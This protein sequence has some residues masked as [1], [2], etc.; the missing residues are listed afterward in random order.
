VC[1]ESFRNCFD[2]WRRKTTR[3]QMTSIRKAA[4]A[5]DLYSAEKVFTEIGFTDSSSRLS[6]VVP[7]ERRR[8]LFARLS[9]YA[10]AWWLSRSLVNP[11]RRPVPC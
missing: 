4:A 6:L 10:E 3:H 2:C 9:Q 8:P 11:G 1:G 5:L 7:D